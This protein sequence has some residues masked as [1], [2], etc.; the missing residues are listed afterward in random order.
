MDSD[1]Q[2]NSSAEYL[3]ENEIPTQG[4]V[5]GASPSKLSRF[6]LIVTTLT[7]LLMIIGIVYGWG[8]VT[9]YRNTD[10]KM[11]GYVQPRSIA[12]LVDLVQDS[13][14]SIYCEFGSDGDYAHCIKRLGTVV[15]LLDC[16]PR[17]C[18][19]NFSLIIYKWS[20]TVSA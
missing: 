19:D 9:Q 16:R 18:A 17:I 10:P 8:P 15:L 11:D 5:D 1:N 6:N 13:T 12:D 14:V 7:F 4:T 20:P 2:E 3:N